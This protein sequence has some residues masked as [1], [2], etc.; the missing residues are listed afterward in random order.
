MGICLLILTTIIFIF[1]N[2]HLLYM[3]LYFSTPVLCKKTTAFCLSVQKKLKILW[4]HSQYFLIFCIITYILLFLIF[5][6]MSVKYKTWLILVTWYRQRYA[7]EAI[8]SSFWHKDSME[9]KS[10]FYYCTLY[11]CIFNFSLVL[12]GFPVNIVTKCPNIN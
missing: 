12:L 1:Q 11:V 5:M 4:L 6:K 3:Y 10:F 9:K 7:P 8:A 2:T